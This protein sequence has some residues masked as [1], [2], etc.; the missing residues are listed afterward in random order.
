MIFVPAS[1]HKS[2][3]G[4]K[5]SFGMHFFCSVWF[6]GMAVMWYCFSFLSADI[7]GS[8]SSVGIATGYGMDGPGIEYRWRGR[9]STPVN[10]GPGAHPASCTMSIRS[11]PGVKS[12]RGVTLT[13]HP[14][15]VLWSRKSRVIPLLH[16]WAVRPV[17]SLCTCTSVNFTFFYSH[18]RPSDSPHSLSLY[19]WIEK[20]KS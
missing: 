3:N 17:K 11:F 14:L 13:P 9:F 18:N 12:G 20:I 7:S 8:G 16:L 1:A 6:S 19:T 2:S 10:T 15:L 4:N 5:F